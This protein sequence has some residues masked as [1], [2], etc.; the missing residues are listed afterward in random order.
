LRA[1]EQ[2]P[3]TRLAVLVTGKSSPSEREALRQRVPES[4][5]E[6][7]VEVLAY[8]GAS[9]GESQIL[10]F[11]HAIDAG[12][13]FVA[14]LRGGGQDAPESLPELLAPLES[15]TADAVFAA[16]A[17]S[18][19]GQSLGNRLLTRL[20]HTLLGTSFSELNPSYRLYS[21]GALRR[22]PFEKNSPDT[23]F[24]AQI[25][26]QLRGTGARIV[27]QAVQAPRDREPPLAEGLKYALNTAK[28]VI[29]YELYEFGLQYHPE[30]VVPPAHTMK[31]G[32]LS[33]HSQI[34]KLIGDSPRRILD[35]GCGPGELGHVL[36]QRGHHVF[37]VDSL[38]PR[39]ELDGFEQAD[40]G[41][42]LP[43]SLGG[44]FDWVLL[45]DVLEHMVDPQKLLLEAKQRLT[46]GGTLLVSLPNA[47]HWSM[48]AQLAFGHFN[49]T[50]KGLL[51]RGHLRFFTRA[52]AAR[53][54][55]DAGLVIVAQRT[56]P[57]PWEN[58]LPRALGSTLRNVAERADHVLTRLRPNLFA[59]QHLFALRVIAK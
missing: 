2:R 33:S 54:F 35:I 34:L 7:V 21:C 55:R 25:I 38:K 59:Y 37:G 50:N 51:D 26:L 23:H 4:T 8:E 49:Y 11:R 46:P 39:L 30:Y 27:E 47:V 20:E 45:A 3:K 22:I 10:G 24:D 29:D 52:S 13:D 5:R 17:P 40:I 56:T 28:A 6:Q 1:A 44:S 9:R 42:G 19:A 36:K 43:T 12:Y 41:Q 57:V 15:D 58:V 48:R 32:E 31:H 16:R 18:S 53:M 14:V